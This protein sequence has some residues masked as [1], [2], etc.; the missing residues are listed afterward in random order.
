MSDGS[1]GR[2]DTRPG[3]GITVRPEAGVTLA[4]EVTGGIGAGGPVLVFWPAMGIPARFYRPFAAAL[5]ARG[6]TAVVPDIRGQGASTPG[7]D[8]RARFGYHA[9]S[10]VDF[11]AVLAAVRDRYPDRRVLLGGH[12]LGGQLSVTF[13]GRR[14][15]AVDGLVLVAASNPHFRAQP[16]LTGAKILLA[17][18]V[19]AAVARLYGYWPGDRLRFMGR[20]SRVLLRDWAHLARTG[21]L[22]FAGS[23]GDAAAGLGRSRLPV[24]SVSVAGDRLAPPSAVDRLVSAFPAEL[25]TRV[26][27]EPATAV[28][29]VRWVRDPAGIA[30]YVARWARSVEGGPAPRDG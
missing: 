20:Q 6:V 17:T 19:M 21:R 7:V 26:H 12:S 24:L 25:V 22:E 13:A 4:A 30:E 14:P 28:D 29:H 2:A 11:P 3:I 16:P 23:D 1:A 8:R 5:A 27:H 10:A 15:A 18:Q 9:V